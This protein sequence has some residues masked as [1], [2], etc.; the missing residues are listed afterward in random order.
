MRIER[1][2]A[3][4]RSIRI[5]HLECRGP[6]AASVRFRC[7]GHVAD[8]FHSSIQHRAF[9]SGHRTTCTAA[10]AVRIPSRR[11]LIGR[12]PRFLIA[13]ERLRSAAIIVLALTYSTSVFAGDPEHQTFGCNYRA[14]I[15][16]CRRRWQPW[17]R[18][19][20]LP[21]RAPIGASRPKTGRSAHVITRPT[22]RS[23]GVRDPGENPDHS[24]E[25][26]IALDVRH[27]LVCAKDDLLGTQRP[28]CE[29]RHYL[30][31]RSCANGLPT[32]QPYTLQARPQQA[33]SDLPAG[34][35]GDAPRGTVLA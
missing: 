9:A 3:F 16:L 20:D 33:L 4:A 7:D 1:A 31:P 17:G 22:R 27:K 19:L 24:V 15:N 34:V 11:R 29:L 32:I 8:R 25:L 12:P 21:A 6:A 26:K 10:V 30:Q 28:C 35:R 14:C 13:P 23:V 18:K 5:V 2:L